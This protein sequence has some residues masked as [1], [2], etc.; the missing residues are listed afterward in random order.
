MTCT[1]QLDSLTS[2]AL[3]SMRQFEGG[4]ARCRGAFEAECVGPARAASLERLEMAWA[5][6]RRQFGADYNGRLL[7]GLLAL[8]VAAIVVARFLLR[9]RL[10]ELAGWAAL[11]FL[12]LYPK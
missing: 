8:A 2:M 6:A 4:F 7:T 12:E 5:R 1:R 9:S 11:V 3:P 10:L